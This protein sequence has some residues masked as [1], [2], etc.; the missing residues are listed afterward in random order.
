MPRRLSTSAA[1]RV[2]RCA[3]SAIAP[4]TA[5]A[6]A[7]VARC[8]CLRGQ[9]TR[10]RTKMISDPITQRARHEFSKPASNFPKPRCQLGAVLRES[11][12][13]TEQNVTLVVQCVEARR[14]LGIVDDL[15]SHIVITP[16]VVCVEKFLAGT[17]TIS[18]M[19]RPT[20][21]NQVVND[22]AN[23][24]LT[25]RAAQRLRDLA[26]A[27]AVVIVNRPT[28]ATPAAH[29][30]GLRA[31]KPHKPLPASLEPFRPRAPRRWKPQG[32]RSKNNPRLPMGVRSHTIPRSS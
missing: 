21:K 7:A 30:T 26:P 4:R 18:R 1:A 16:Q 11:L 31:P 6:R 22:L 29:G 24:V 9:A 19:S 20:G 27:P 14:S 15:L 25:C 5:S 32:V 10:A 3:V 12:S 28:V 8:F 13:R 23:F 17:P 2:E